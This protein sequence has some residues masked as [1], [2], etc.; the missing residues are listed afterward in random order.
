MMFGNQQQ[1][2]RKAFAC[3]IFFEESFE[4]TSG[5]TSF[6]IHARARASIADYLLHN[7]QTTYSVFE[8]AELI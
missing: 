6:C 8:N 7:L 3:Y 5:E 1:K 4:N 2:S